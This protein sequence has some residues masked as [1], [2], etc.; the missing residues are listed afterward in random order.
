MPLRI[1]KLAVIC[2]VPLILWLVGNSEVRAQIPIEDQLSA[3]A[4][5][6]PTPHDTP[7][8]VIEKLTAEGRTLH[9]VLRMKAP[10]LKASLESA[11]G[12]LQ[13]NV[14]KSQAENQIQALCS[15]VSTRQL[16]NSGAA[17]EDRLLFADGTPFVTVRID[18]AACQNQKK[19]YDFSKEGKV[20]PTAVARIKSIVDLAKLPLNMGV[21]SITHMEAD[22][23]LLKRRMVL[24]FEV[25]KEQFN[26]PNQDAMIRQQCKNAYL[27]QLVKD[28]G[29]FEDTVL[30][31]QGDVLGI[32]VTDRAACHRVTQ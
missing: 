4:S 8:V 12:V 2:A 22:G 9:R 28:G 15:N 19:G 13:E 14:R 10:S 3:I 26:K 20:E 29:R 25:T 1:N 6:F 17:F 27:A 5:S 21:A 31:K 32:V 16:I 24:N 23:V 30:N 18:A 7:E 11:P